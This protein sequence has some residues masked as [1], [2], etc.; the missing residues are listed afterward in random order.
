MET[1]IRDATGGVGET[2]IEER[3]AD[4]TLKLRRGTSC[5]LVHPSRAA[6]L[7][8]FNEAFSKKAR[9]VESCQ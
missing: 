1:R 5:V 9:G 8:P 3:L 7:D 6:T 4:G 2:I